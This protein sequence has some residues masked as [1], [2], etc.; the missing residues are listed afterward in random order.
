M[1]RAIEFLVV[2][3]REDGKP[4]AEVFGDYADAERR[5]FDLYRNGVRVHIERRISHK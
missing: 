2:Y 4:E 5:Y 1:A 3:D